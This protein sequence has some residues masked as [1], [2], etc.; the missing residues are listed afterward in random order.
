LGSGKGRQAENFRDE[1]RETGE[2]RK[3]RRGG[4]KMEPIGE[5]EETEPHSP[6]SHKYWGF[7]R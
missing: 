4:D 2:E 5:E 1:D 6:G 7:L 3:E